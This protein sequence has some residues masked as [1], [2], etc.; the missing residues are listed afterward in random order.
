[1]NVYSEAILSEN[2]L[3][4]KEF[5]CDSLKINFL[6][7]NR[8]ILISYNYS[9]FDSFWL[10][11]IRFCISNFSKWA[12]FNLFWDLVSFGPSSNAD[13]RL[14]DMLF[15]PVSV[16]AVSLAGFFIF[17]NVMAGFNW[18]SAELVDC[19]EELLVVLGPSGSFCSVVSCVMLMVTDCWPVV[20]VFGSVVWPSRARSFFL[21]KPFLNLTS[22]LSLRSACSVLVRDS[23][24]SRAYRKW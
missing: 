13:L 15:V 24:A 11:K 20:V 17:V 8:L 9:C 14:C 2:I 10:F 21:S 7:N 22:F 1:M 4:N 6:N 16:L 3:Q 23:Q 19:R 18:I 5:N 12:E